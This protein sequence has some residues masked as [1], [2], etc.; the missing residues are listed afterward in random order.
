MTLSS[1]LADALPK[2]TKDFTSRAGAQFWFEWRRVGWL[3]PHCILLV[4]TFAF[5][6]SWFK[7]G[8]PV[9]VDYLLSWLLLAPLVLSAIV[10]KGFVKCE[11]W[12]AN[13]GLPNFIA[14]RPLSAVEYVGAKLKVAAASVT[15]AW[16]LLLGFLLLWLSLW[17][18]ATELKVSLFL[19][20]ERHPHSWLAIGILYF[21]GLM[22][23]SWRLMV[24][25]LWIGLRGHRDFY[26]AWS[27]VQI[28]VPALGLL[29]AGI[30]SDWID[31]ECQTN[32]VLM[33]S[34]AINSLGWC[35]SALVIA[36]YWLAARTWAGVELNFTRR[37]LVFWAGGL[38]C[39]LALALLASPFYDVY[40][41]KHLYL[42]TA[43]LGFPLA[44]C[45]LA[46]RS[47]AKN[48]YR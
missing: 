36:K 22:I 25:G 45:G 15:V 7:R 16:L 21:V 37:Y 39:L 4:I 12:S 17:A 42:L 43:L 14:V 1:W 29:A 35:L 5:P 24:G 46:P 19:Y 27:T 38:A 10:G 32:P 3:L 33:H 18:D 30:W 31:S 34:L 44:R 26:M 20:R 41:L 48:R 28:L 9:F 13:F 47:F 40:R 8:D 6:I 2:R 11:F 23:L